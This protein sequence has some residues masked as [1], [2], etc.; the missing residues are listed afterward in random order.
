MK[1]NITV[2][3]TAVFLLAA[4]FFGY[5]HLNTQVMASDAKID[6]YTLEDLENKS[7]AII[8]ASVAKELSTDIDFDERNIPYNY[9]TYSSLNVEKVYNSKNNVQKN[10]KIK[11]VEFYADW[12]DLRGSYRAITGDYYKPLEPGKDY[13]LFLFKQ[14][15]RD[16]YEIIGVHQGK[17]VINA[18][19]L[20]EDGQPIKERLTPENLDI[21]EDEPHYIEKASQVLNKYK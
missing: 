17:Y 13:I 20:G 3:F 16:Y 21:R 19:V 12:R 1:K 8:K 5:Q 2:L 14:E 9:R 4:G 7:T 11:V 10:D 6:L 18:S 15:G